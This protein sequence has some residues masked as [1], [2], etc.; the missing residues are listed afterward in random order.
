MKILFRRK[1]RFSSAIF[2]DIGER[3]ISRFTGDH[4]SEHMLMS[5]KKKHENNLVS[6]EMQESLFKISW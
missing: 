1:L 5:L 4:M 3:K 2:L 6:S